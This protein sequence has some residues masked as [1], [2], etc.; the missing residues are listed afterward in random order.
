M[1]CTVIEAELLIFEEAPGRARR[2]ELFGRLHGPWSRGRRDRSQ[3]RPGPQRRHSAALP[4]PADRGEPLF[5]PDCTMRRPEPAGCAWWGIWQD[6]RGAAS[7]LSC[8]HD[9]GWNL[10]SDPQ[11]SGGKGA[12]P[13]W[14]ARTR[15]GLAL[16]PG[17]RRDDPRAI[18]QAVRVLGQPRAGVTLP[19][20]LAAGALAEGEKCYPWKM[21]PLGNARRS[22]GP[23]KVPPVCLGSYGKGLTIGRSDEPVWGLSRESI[24]LCLEGE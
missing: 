10:R 2:P 14:R 4:A 12:G 6:P 17:I 5:H 23:R 7:P 9:R 20:L 24:R 1:C 21:R 15:H 22:F 16:A 11:Y 3:R 18:A 19:A 8:E 13:A